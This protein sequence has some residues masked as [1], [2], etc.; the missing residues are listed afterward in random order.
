MWEIS[1]RVLYPCI[2]LIG[3]YCNSAPFITIALLPKG[4]GCGIITA[5]GSH[6][7][8]TPVVPHKCKKIPCTLHNS[9]MMGGYYLFQYVKNEIYTVISQ[10]IQMHL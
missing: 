9:V 8:G 1:T 4:F 10:R 3:K 6:I 5:F 7:T 2:E